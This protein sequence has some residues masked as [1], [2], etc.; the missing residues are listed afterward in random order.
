MKN[1]GYYLIKLEDKNI[2][3]STKKGGIFSIYAKN[4]VISDFGWH[5]IY[6]NKELVNNFWSDKWSS[7]FQLNKNNF[8]ITISGYL[9]MHKQILS[10]PL[11]HFLLRITSFIFGNLLIK[12]LK[13][14]F[15]FKKNLN[16]LPF[17]RI[18]KI[19]D[20]KIIIR[21]RINIYHSGKLSR[22]PRSS[23]RH[24]SSSD[25]FHQEDFIKNNFRSHTNNISISEKEIITEYSL[26]EKK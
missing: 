3:I 22:A 17:S 19:Y 1:S 14:K 24:V 13:N 21:D 23:K 20:D 12:F 6:K 25:S 2:V 10:N 26:K 9:Y 4:K 18:I 7:K 11:N 15:I 5:F 8:E 16:D